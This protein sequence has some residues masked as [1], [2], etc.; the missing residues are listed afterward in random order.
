MYD[1]TFESILDKSYQPHFKQ[2]GKFLKKAAAI[3]ED[4]SRQEYDLQDNQQQQDQEYSNG[5]D[6]M[7]ILPEQHVL[8]DEFRY[9]AMEYHHLFPNDPM[10]HKPLH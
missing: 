10:L 2:G 5:D 4:M 1:I 7:E 9:L 3:M 8:F 6:E